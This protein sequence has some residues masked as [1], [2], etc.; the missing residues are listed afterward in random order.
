M[1][2]LMAAEVNTVEELIRCLE[3]F[4]THDGSENYLMG[5]EQNGFTVE[6]VEHEEGRYFAH[7]IRLTE[8]E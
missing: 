6:L 5:K 3:D 4:K 8:K 7:D 1:K 2:V